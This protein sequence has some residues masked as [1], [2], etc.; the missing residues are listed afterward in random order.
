MNKLEDIRMTLNI[1]KMKSFKTNITLKDKKTV[2]TCFVKDFNYD[3]NDTKV[4]IQLIEDD[5]K[6]IW[7]YLSKIKSVNKIE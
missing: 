1:L 5:M 4:L 7:L 3:E 2:Y 6:E